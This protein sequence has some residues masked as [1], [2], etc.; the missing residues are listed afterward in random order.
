MPVNA[1]SPSTRPPAAV[2]SAALG[3]LALAACSF[4]TAAPPSCVTDS[5]CSSGTICFVDGCADPTRELAVEVTGSSLTGIFPQDFEVKELGAS[6]D[7]FLPG[8][9]TIGGSFQLE[10]TAGVD[11]TQRD[12]YDSEVLVRATGE[13]VLLPGVTRSYQSRFAKTDR[14]TFSM[15]VGQG[16]YSVTALPTD[17]GVPPMT[18]TNVLAGLDAGGALNFAF[19]SDQ[20][21]VKLSGRLLRKRLA[22]PPPTD[23]VV[24]QAEM[25]LQAFDPAT[26]EPLSQR[27]ATSS[28]H[29]GATGD[30]ILVMSPLARSLPVIEVVATPRSLDALVPTRRFALRPPF[31]ANVT[32]ELGDFGEVIPE[33]RGVVLGVEGEPLAGASVLFEGRVGGEG[34]FRSR[35]VETGPDGAFTVDLLPSDGTFTMTVFPA[36]GARSGVTQ[37]QARVTSAPGAPP[38]LTPQRLRCRERLLVRGTV[39]LADQSPAAMI[40]VRA[41]ETSKSPTRPLPLEDVEVLTDSAGVYELRLDPGSWSLEFLPT[42]DLPQTSRLVTVSTIAASDGDTLDRQQL[43]PIVLPR[44]RRVTGVVTSN[45]ANRGPTPLS[46]AQVRFFRVTRIENKPASVLLGTGVTNGIGVYTV[47]LPTREAPRAQE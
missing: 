28:G 5:D 2:F 45:V 21:V 39:L 36:P 6:Q 12:I 9:I 35:L 46:N 47:I 26:G 44:G 41:V 29:A 18:F 4:G 24:T 17:P 34:V 19:A 40:R 38:A 30:F 37:T 23:L 31:A 42:G 27:G 10:R 25:E 15:G 7:F 8:P 16:R 33:V 14:G 3:A 11:P 13:S 1:P 22:G 32:L 43:A 20:G